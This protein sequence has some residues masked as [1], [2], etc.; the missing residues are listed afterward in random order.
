MANMREFLSLYEEDLAMKEI[1]K[2]LYTRKLP[3]ILDALKKKQYEAF[4]FDTGVQAKQ[5]ILDRIEPSETIAIGGSITV[6]QDLGIVEELTKRGHT[7]YDHWQAGKDRTR[8]LELKRKNREADVFISGLNAVT[9][10]GILVNLDGGGNRVAS[11]CSGP[12][13]VI[14]VAGINKIVESLDLAIQRT[15]QKAAVMTALRINSKTPCV[16]TGVCSDCSAAGRICAALL[17]LY[18]KPTDIDQ[19]TVILV[20][21]RLG[22]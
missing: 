2:K 5:F 3:K 18:K 4:L 21:E 10:G 14:A 8:Q 20:N 11:L 15:R 9:S 13:K 22:F 16:E 7:V 12:K 1:E 17:I 19:F 6:R